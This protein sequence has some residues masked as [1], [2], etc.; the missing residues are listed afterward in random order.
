MA[1]PSRTPFT[2]RPP[3]VGW[4]RTNGSGA[5]EKFPVTSDSRVFVDD[6]SRDGRLAL[7]FETPPT[8]MLLPLA[9]DDP[10]RPIGA[11][12]KVAKGST[13]RFS[14]DGA[15]IAF[16]DRVGSGD[17]VNVF[18]QHLQSGRRHQV[19]TDGGHGPVWAGSGRELFFRDGSTMMAAQLSIEGTSVRIGRPSRLFDGDFLDIG[20][21]VSPDAKPFVM[22]RLANASTHALSVRL[23]WNTEL[24][25]LVP[26]QR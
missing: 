22:V 18:V 20:Y 19:S 14:P 21:D 13:P 8:V 9:G 12:V 17:A 26:I 5:A 7:T 23:N 16:A 6:W 15:W 24:E 25:R 2:S 1:T 10:P 3:Q 11:P 4:S